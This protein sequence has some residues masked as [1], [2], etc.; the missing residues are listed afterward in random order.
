MMMIK[1][2]NGVGMKHWKS[3]GFNH[4][5]LIIEFSKNNPLFLERK[6]SNSKKCVFSPCT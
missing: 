2:Y 3:L 6:V 1:K 5:Q 4:S